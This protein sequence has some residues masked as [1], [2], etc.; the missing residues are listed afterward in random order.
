MIT[1]MD[2]FQWCKKDFIMLFCMWTNE[3]Q[4]F[5]FSNDPRIH[6]DKSMAHSLPAALVL[7]L[8]PLPSARGPKAL[9][10]LETH[11]CLLFWQVSVF[12]CLSPVGSNSSMLS[13][14]PRDS[15]CVCE[16]LYWT[17]HSKSLTFWTCPV[18]FGFQNITSA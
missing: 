13:V 5:G 18:D 7:F 17:F 4:V 3:H 14:K 15:G 2:A 12:R 11:L 6:P 16:S 10:P 9:C 8:T 1:S